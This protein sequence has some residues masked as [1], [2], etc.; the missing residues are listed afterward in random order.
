ML[1][2]YEQIVRFLWPKNWKNI[3]IS[4]WP[5]FYRHWPVFQSTLILF[6]ISISSSAEDWKRR[7]I[8][9]MR[10]FVVPH[11]SLTNWW[12]L[13]LTE[14]VQTRHLYSRLEKVQTYSC[15]HCRCNRLRFETEFLVLINKS[16][17]CFVIL[18]LENKLE[19]IIM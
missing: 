9:K 16:I 3:N 19:I 4:I 5:V 11:R 1:N 2:V 15:L 17:R 7:K 13:M 12:A 6:L 14:R 8:D 18:Q 10:E